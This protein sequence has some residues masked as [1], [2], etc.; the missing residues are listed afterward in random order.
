M[1]KRIKKVKA[2]VKKVK[3]KPKKVVR[4]AGAKKPKKNEATLLKERLAKLRKESNAELNRLRE[5]V[6]YKN[7]QLASK[8]VDMESYKKV[9]EEKIFQ[10]EAKVKELEG[11]LGGSSFTS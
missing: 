8:D 4:S 3:T 5:E 7:K 6:D 9:T 1:A 11:K 2:K 10:L